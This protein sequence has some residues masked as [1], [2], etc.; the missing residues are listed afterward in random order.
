[1]AHRFVPLCNCCVCV[2]IVVILSLAVTPGKWNHLLFAL[3][4]V[5]F[6]VIWYVW[7]LGVVFVSQFTVFL[8]SFC[9][10]YKC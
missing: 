2:C 10:T 8:F 9:M 1:M 5:E 4:L 6:N 7:Y 3:T